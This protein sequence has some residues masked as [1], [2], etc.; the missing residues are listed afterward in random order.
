MATLTR[1]LITEDGQ[2]AGVTRAHGSFIY[3]VRLPGINRHSCLWGTITE[4]SQP[5]GEPLDF[6][7]IGAASMAIMNV[8]PRDDGVVDVWAQINWDSDLNLRIQLMRVDP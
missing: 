8:A 7:F 5:T 6:P 3:H 1:F 4:V 2:P